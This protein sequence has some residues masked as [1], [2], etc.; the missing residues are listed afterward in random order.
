VRSDDGGQTWASNVFVAPS[1]PLPG[2]V[3]R[4]WLAFGAGDVVVLTF[5]QVPTG[6]Y[7]AVSRDAGATFGAF[8]RIAAGQDRGTGYEG[9]PLVEP[10]G[11]ILVPFA[12]GA[13]PTL[14]SRIVV[15]SSD[16]DGATWRNVTVHATSDGSQDAG[17]A[18]VLALVAPERLAVAWPQ[19]NGS[20]FRLAVARSDD[21]GRSWT[22]PA[23]WGPAYGSIAP[24]LAGG[25]GR[26][27]AAWHAPGIDVMFGRDEGAG[28]SEVRIASSVTATHTDESALAWLPDGRAVVAWNDGNRLLVAT[29]ASGAEAGIARSS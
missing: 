11:R 27:D 29:E 24:W 19:T 4:P 5:S 8:A 20:A 7:V 13:P 18:P 1:P 14:D 26:L 25:G 22:A 28:P 23:D 21:D 3:D 12:A 10:G 6:L 17:W 9:P 16:D 2:I 15:A